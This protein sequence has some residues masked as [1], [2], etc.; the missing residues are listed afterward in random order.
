MRW[1]IDFGQAANPEIPR[2]TAA[3]TDLTDFAALNAAEACETSL[4]ID[5]P[6]L[7]ESVKFPGCIGQTRRT[8]DLLPTHLA[9]DH[10]KSHGCRAPFA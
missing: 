4:T 6:S 5:A 2:F 7:R 10:S 8:D 9:R 3:G 1:K